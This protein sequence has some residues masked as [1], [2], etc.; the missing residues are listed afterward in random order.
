MNKFGIMI[1]S[2]FA[3][4]WFVWGLSATSPIS[5][6]W[7][8]VPFAVSGAMMAAAMRLPLWRRRVERQRTGRIVGWASAIEG[9]AIFAAVN[10]LYN[11]GLA[12]YAAVAT[13]AIVALHFL[14]LAYYLRVPT[15][16]LAG[17]ALL[18][19]AVF[20]C[21]ITNEATRLLVVGTGAATLLWLTCLTSFARQ[22]TR[23]VV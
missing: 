21:T 8:L 23:A 4:L 17:A 13:L 20:G 2:G 16:Y 15:Y 5:G 12:G 1:M 18:G 22:P 3:V 6:L 11:T 7:L 14:P 9:V 19:L 10:V